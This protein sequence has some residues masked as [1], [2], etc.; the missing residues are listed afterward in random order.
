GVC[1]FTDPIQRPLGISV[2]RVLPVAIPLLLELPF[3]RWYRKRGAK[4][5]AKWTPGQ[6][7]VSVSPKDFWKTPRYNWPMNK[8]HI[9]GETVPLRN[10]LKVDV[11][12]HRKNRHA[13]DYRWRRR[14]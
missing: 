12:E 13:E 8:C 4:I 9:C 14:A 6:E 2:F 7:P 3:L 1:F 11:E 5:R 10:G